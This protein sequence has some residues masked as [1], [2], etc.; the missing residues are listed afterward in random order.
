MSG[1]GPRSSRRRVSWRTR[2]M[3]ARCSSAP[4]SR[5][6]WRGTAA[7]RWCCRPPGRRSTGSS[8][9]CC[10]STGLFRLPAKSRR[11][12]QS[13]A[14]RHVRVAGRGA[15]GR[16]RRDRHHEPG[17]V[18][19][20]PVHVPMGRAGSDGGDRCVHPLDPGVPVDAVLDPGRRSRVAAVGSA[21]ADAG[22][23]SLAGGCGV[24]RIAGCRRTWCC[25][26]SSCRGERRWRRGRP[27][28]RGRS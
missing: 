13:R 14:E 15:A 22:G 27:C 2:R 20:R 8:M 23:W 9:R 11:S 3:C 28:G 26:R 12:A 7:S 6:G 24:S 5:A 21:V 16:V 10:G 4:G 17:C 25:A 1:Y 18:R 19:D